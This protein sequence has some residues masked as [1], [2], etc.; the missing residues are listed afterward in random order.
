MTLPDD[1]D[2]NK[3]GEYDITFT[4]TNE[5]GASVTTTKKLTVLDRK[6]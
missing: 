6:E 4:R 3:P 2:P 1:Y 5:I